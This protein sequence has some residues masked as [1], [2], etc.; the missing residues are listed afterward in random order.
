MGTE[1]PGR[2]R[3]DIRLYNTCMLKGGNT[4]AVTFLSTSCIQTDQVFLGHLE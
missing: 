2:G 3:L 1:F 4:D